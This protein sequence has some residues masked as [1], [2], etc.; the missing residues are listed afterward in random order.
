MPPITN[1]R[2]LPADWLPLQAYI[3]INNSQTLQPSYTNKD[4]NVRRQAPT[5]TTVRVSTSV[6]INYVISILAVNLLE[7]N[8][9]IFVKTLDVLTSKPCFAIMG[10][11]VDWH[12]PSLTT[13]LRAE[14]AD[15]FQQGHSEG[16]WEKMAEFNNRTP[17][18][19]SFKLQKMKA[20]KASERVSDKDQEFMDYY[21]NLRSVIAV[22]EPDGNYEWACTVLEDF[23]KAGLLKVLVSR[24][25]TVKILPGNETLLRDINEYTRSLKYQMILNSQTSLT[26]MDSV[27]SMH[28]AVVVEVVEGSKRPYKKT[29]LKREL[30]SLRLAPTKEGEGNPYIEGAQYVIDSGSPHGVGSVLLMHL[31]TDEVQDM[32]SNLCD[33]PAS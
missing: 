13:E 11:H 21:H 28:S 26:R 22:E 12:L 18:L 31:N 14:I 4:G 7:H 30:L 17:P 10:T 3:F 20:P 5:Y 32:I 15:F 29:H 1:S 33:S 16:K 2:Q 27:L 24:M 9:K 8:C 25:A 6:E 23:R 19:L